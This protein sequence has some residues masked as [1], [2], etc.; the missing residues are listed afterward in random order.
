MED[1]RLVFKEYSKICKE[2]EKRQDEIKKRKIKF[3]SEL[4][5]SQPYSITKV[6]K[7][8]AE[9]AKSIKPIKKEIEMLE[10]QKRVMEVKYK[11]YV[12]F[13]EF[14][15]NLKKSSKL[16][17]T[18]LSYNIEEISF[19]WIRKQNEI[20]RAKI[21]DALRTG[22]FSELF[23]IIIYNKK[24]SFY[25]LKRMDFGR[26]IKFSDNSQVKD[27]ISIN[28]DIIPYSIKFTNPEKIMLPFSL[29]ELFKKSDAWDDKTLRKAVLDAYIKI[30]PTPKNV[31]E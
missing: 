25:Y 14:F 15:D 22:D 20:S 8:K 1:I 9:F 2:I 10:N 28:Y 24:T 13:G 18:S 16:K 29:N 3:N 4:D 6:E 5:K 19:P 23:D 21:Q 30:N 31:K 7:A 11:F 12:P 27:N 26:Y 17:D